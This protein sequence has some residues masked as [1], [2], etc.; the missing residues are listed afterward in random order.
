[1]RPRT[2]KVAAA[3]AT[4]FLA[5]TLA[6]AASASGGVTIEQGNDWDGFPAVSAPG[7]T[8]SVTVCTFQS[9]AEGANATV[10]FSGLKNV[11]SFVSS[12]DGTVSSS[13]KNQ[14]TISYTDY[15]HSAKCD[16][17]TFTLDAA[18]APG[19]YP[20]ERTVKVAGVGNAHDTLYITIPEPVVPVTFQAPASGTQLC[21]SV[22]GATFFADNMDIAAT[23]MNGGYWAPSA[24]GFT[25][26]GTPLLSC[27][28]P[29]AGGFLNAPAAGSYTD[30][31]GDVLSPSAAVL[32]DYP[33]VV[34]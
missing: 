25:A 8:V 7:D 14:V 10:K 32:G 18:L 28:T 2:H 16:G 1:M 30:N 27:L 5:L 24:V 9:G 11:A 20:I 15:A 12:G 21:Y 23:L 19:T 17:Y 4:A 6:A 26:G 22:G 33:V 34:G 29:L 31:D 13:S 3:A